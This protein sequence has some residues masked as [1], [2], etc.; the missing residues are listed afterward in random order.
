M[1]NMEYLLT[2][3]MFWNPEL[4]Y[5]Y[6]TRIDS[7]KNHLDFLLHICKYWELDEIIRFYK[8]N[9]TTFWWFK[10]YYLK[11]VFYKDNEEILMRN[12]KFFFK[13]MNAVL[14]WLDLPPFTELIQYDEEIEQEKKD[15][16]RALKVAEDIIK[17]LDIQK[18]K[19]NKKKVKEYFQNKRKAKRSYWLNKLKKLLKIS[20]S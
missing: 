16:A 14:V 6:N 2:P 8:N 20:K 13:K 19:E 4:L 9:E 10:K 5:L 15:D 18:T 1:K 11:Y 17:W 3:Y 12:N 7:A